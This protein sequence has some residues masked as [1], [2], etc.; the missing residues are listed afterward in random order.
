MNRPIIGIP[1]RPNWSKMDVPILNIFEFVRKP[2]IDLG[3]N[4]FLILP[5]QIIDYVDTKGQD[6]PKLTTLDKKLL[7]S[8]LDICDGILMPGGFKFFEHDRFIL[9]YAIKNNIPILGIC[10][11]M[12]IMSCYGED[13]KLEANNTDINHFQLD[14]KYSHK[15][16]LDKN[17]KLAQILKK[18]EL[19]VN[20]MHNYH[21]LENKYYKTVGFS[22]DGLIEAI[23]YNDND[24]NIGVQWHPEK[25]YL[26]DEDARKLLDAFL[27]AAKKRQSKKASKDK[28]KHRNIIKV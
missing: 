20:S 24:F 13:V 4:P 14:A 22:E 8:W 21:A 25:M 16:T 28:Q 11:G 26:Y 18:T 15:V 5:P 9:E 2:I 23:E 1:A 27:K 19:N 12:Q 10:L 3:G 7:T 6:M 17:S